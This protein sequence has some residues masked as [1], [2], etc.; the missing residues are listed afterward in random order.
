MGRKQFIR[1]ISLFLS[2]MLIFAVLPMTSFANSV[3]EDVIAKLKDRGFKSPVNLGIG[4]SEVVLLNAAFGKENGRDVVYATANGGVFNVVDVKD[5]K[6]IFSQQLA[7]VSQVWSHSIASNGTVYI[8]AL[9][10]GN[11]GEL[12]SYSPTTKIVEKLG[13]PNAGHQAWSST[14]DDNGNAY[15]GTYAEGNGRI[16]KYDGATKSFVDFGKIDA[17]NASYI[18]SLEYH[19]GYLYAGLGVEGKVYRI[20]VETME[21]EEITKNVPDILGKP[22]SQIK[23][24]YDMAVVGNY[25]FARFDDGGESA[26]LFYD[27]INQEWVSDKKLGKL[28]DGSADDFGSFG[29]IQLPVNGDKAYVIHNRHIVEVDINTL[30]TR[31]T[32]IRY[33]AGL[34]GGAFV[35]MGR[36][37]L[38]G[39]SLVTMNRTGQI[40]AAN[41]ETNKTV[42]LPTAM[43][44]LPLRLHNLG[45]GPD[46]NLYMT[47][48]P[49]GPKGSKYNIQTGQFVTYSQGQAEGIVAGNGNDLYFG[50][51]GG[52]AIQR[53]NTETMAIETLFD[54]KPEQQDRP[55][56]MKFVENKLLIGTIPDYQK[57]GGALTIYDSVT[58]DRKTY[59]NVVQDQSIVGLSHKD[60]LIY[61]ST[62]VRGGLDIPP[63]TSKAKMFIWDMESEQ[64]LKEFE[65]DIPELDAP[66]IISGLTFDDNGTLWGAVDGIIFAMDPATQEV[67]KYKNIYPEIKNRGMWRPVHI[68][69]GKDGLL[70]TDVGGKLTVI[71]PSSENLDHVSL[72]NSGPEIDF[73]V[74]A[75]D[76][77]GNENI[78]YID[79]DATHLF[80]I[81]VVDGGEV[82][83]PE[84]PIYETVNV[85]IKNAGFEDKVKKESI[86]GWSSLFGAFPSNASFE[87]SELRKSY[88]KKSLKINDT[89]QKQTV[90]AQTDS[91]SI[92]EGVEY[93]ASTNLF[94]EDGSVS[95]FIRYFDETG[96]QV[97]S[98]RDGENIIHIRNG[99]KEWQ[100]VK[101]TVT[102]PEG[103]KYARL[104]A[105]TSNYF[106]TTAAYFDDFKL[107]YEKEVT[108]PGKPGKPDKP[109][110]PEK[111]KPGKPGKPGK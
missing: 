76:K 22:V 20:N 29:F 1:A 89:D 102:A 96:I 16:Y 18:R 98:D 79:G 55:Y 61:G 33:G 36:E 63:S 82:V 88:G 62:T 108:K 26:I 45:E 81:P 35:D 4:A 19:D 38:P 110:K 107:S 80:M 5:N 84:E 17:G 48:Y 32:G 57:L 87:I 27:L 7:K 24:V 94:L 60:G 106:T 15:I 46:G 103:A 44:A 90:F 3:E 6:L 69:I 51:Y 42:T 59:R 31:E 13:T 34:R 70:Y 50:I 91:I 52:A 77:E 105:G 30:E 104:F 67:I 8:A 65:L 10:E 11:V 85:P 9:G 86:P 111:P 75:N 97:G 21:K 40:F 47:T 12:W 73:M 37:D 66:P 100:T 83:N 109:G 49:G 28:H 25:L 99:H 58:G 74:L 71:D 54:L 101:A 95:F 72:I 93:T 41:L 56:I 92:K 64:K 78:Y 68:E 43:Q 23:F 39:L 2:I 53:M 14:T